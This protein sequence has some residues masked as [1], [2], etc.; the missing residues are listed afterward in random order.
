MPY[1]VGACTYS[2]LLRRTL[3]RGVSSNRTQP[4]LFAKKPARAYWYNL[5]RRNQSCL[6]T[7]SGNKPAM[8]VCHGTPPISERGVSVGCFRL[9]W[10]DNLIHWTN[11]RVTSVVGVVVSCSRAMQKWTRNATGCGSLIGRARAWLV[12][13]GSSIPDQVKPMT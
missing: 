5:T 3:R 12:E 8:V 6:C 13:I 11:L 2:L 1:R 7:Q 9:F 10:I 4:A